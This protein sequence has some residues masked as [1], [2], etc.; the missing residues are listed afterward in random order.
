MTRIN[1]GGLLI[2]GERTSRCGK[3]K[4]KKLWGTKDKGESFCAIL[5]RGGRADTPGNRTGNQK[6]TGQAANV[7]KKTKDE[8]QIGT[9]INQR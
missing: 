9:K 1:S 3:K 4:R 7:P 2:Q 8:D 6:A 5:E